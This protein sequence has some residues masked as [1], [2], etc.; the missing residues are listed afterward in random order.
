MLLR[1]SVFSLVKRVHCL[2]GILILVGCSE[3]D[4]WIHIPDDLKKDLGKQLFYTNAYERY[5]YSSVY[6]FSD[7]WYDRVVPLI[8]KDEWWEQPPVKLDDPAGSVMTAQEQGFAATNC[9]GGFKEYDDVFEEAIKNKNN[10]YWA[11]DSQFMLIVKK[12]R[13][14]FI[15]ITNF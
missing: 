6:S 3:P 14:L 15:A 2:I 7:E 4:P 13:L 10:Y 12:E 5:C 1:P 11:A 9:N 8:L